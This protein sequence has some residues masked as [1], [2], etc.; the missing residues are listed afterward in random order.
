MGA[1]RALV[2]LELL[3]V[4]R[5]ISAGGTASRMRFGLCQMHIFQSTNTNWI[6]CERIELRRVSAV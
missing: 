1:G 6:L 2:R 4:G 3:R 5:M